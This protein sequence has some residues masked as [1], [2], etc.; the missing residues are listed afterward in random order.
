VRSAAV[1][2]IL[3]KERKRGVKRGRESNDNKDIED[4]NAEDNNTEDKNKGSI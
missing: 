4:N 3:E 1:E 2:A